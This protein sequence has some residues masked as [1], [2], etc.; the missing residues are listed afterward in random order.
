MFLIAIKAIFS[1]K[2]FRADGLYLNFLLPASNAVPLD[3]VVHQ[4]S[5][6]KFVSTLNTKTT[7]VGLA[8]WMCFRLCRYPCPHTGREAIGNYG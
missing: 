8:S 7:L 3:E 6:L 1:C 2:N 4:R 5:R